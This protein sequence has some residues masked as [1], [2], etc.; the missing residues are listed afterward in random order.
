M[1]SFHGPPAAADTTGRSAPN[2]EHPGGHHA[3]RLS[4]DARRLARAAADLNTDVIIRMVRASIDDIG[5]I[6]TWEQLVQPVWQYLGSR[7]DRVNRH[8]AAEH[9]YVRAAMTALSLARRRPSPPAVLLACADEELQTFPLEALLAALEE[10]GAPCCLLGARVPPEALA[11]A[12]ARLRPAAVVVW[13]QARD[14]ADPAQ[15]D[16]ALNAYPTATI[17]AAGPGWN[18][19]TLPAQAIRSIDLSTALSLTL[20]ALD[21]HRGPRHDPDESRHRPW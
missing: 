9:M 6:P 1:T 20:A 15:I 14:T 11:T 19:T 18:T 13:S 7:S 21:G 2:V 8:Q 5:V 12:I 17:I 3:I 4:S 10:S 16:T